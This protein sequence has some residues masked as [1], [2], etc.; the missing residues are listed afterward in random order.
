MNTSRFGDGA[1]G[2]SQNEI[3]THR[4]NTGC[5]EGRRGY[6][7]LQIL[8]QQQGQ[9]EKEREKKKRFQH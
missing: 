6:R 9:T 7:S 4:I 8:K 5:K 3:G 1:G 2:D